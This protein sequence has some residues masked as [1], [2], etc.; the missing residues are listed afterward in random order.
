MTQPAPCRILVV[1]EICLLG[2]VS[3]TRDDGAPAD[4][5]PARCRTVLAALALSV[6]SAVPVPRLVELVWGEQ[7]PRTAA[8]TLQSYVTRLRKGLGPES[9]VRTGAAYRLDV[10]AEAVDV[11]R[12]Q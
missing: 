9:V 4:I 5:G 7:P 8:K 1:V 3:A 10:A 12:F 6:G 11:V 2:G